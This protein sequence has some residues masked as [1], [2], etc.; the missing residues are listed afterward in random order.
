VSSINSISADKLIRLI[1]TPKCPALVDV[2]SEEEFAVD[3]RLVPCSVRRACGAVFDWAAE[4]RGRSA[5]IICQDGLGLSGGVAALVRDAGVPAE[6][7]EQGFVGWAN[8]NQPL[9][10][11]DKL[12]PRNRQGRTLWVTRERPKID[13][14]AC[15][16]L[17]RR[18][19]DPAALF[20]FVAPSDVLTVSET[21]DAAAFDVEGVFW[22]HRG[23]TCTFDVM[24]EELGLASPPLLRLAT[25]VRAAD[26]GRLDLAPEAAGLLAASLGLS[27]MYADDLEQLEAGIALYDTFYR[28][29]RD[30]T[31]E[32]HN[33]PTNKKGA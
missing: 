17:I 12:P 26:T 29:C 18:F 2:R 9:I 16:W 22:S 8:G 13:R 33:W 1:G 23:A 28:W 20:M 4:L 25:I 27:R 30:A 7:L 11:A 31:N 10:P 3:P 19:V 24:I 14:I 32:T 15:P 21:F 5:V 6:T